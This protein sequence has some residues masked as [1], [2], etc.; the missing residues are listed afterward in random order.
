M[1]LRWP[2]WPL[3]HRVRPA[4]LVLLAAALLA[5]SGAAEPSPPGRSG[6]AT[7]LPAPPLTVSSTHG[8]LPIAVSVLGRRRLLPA[9]TTLAGCVAQLGLRPPA[10]SLLA[11]DRTVLRPAV[12]P[13]RVLLNGRPAPAATP[14][15]RDDRVTLLAGRDRVE[16]VR[17]TLLPPV[18]PDQPRNP[19]GTLVTGPGHEVLTSGSISGRLAG[20]V[21]VPSGPRHVPRAVA[22][23]FDDGP[24]PD[25][26]AKVLAILRQAHAPATFFVVGRQVLRHPELV[27]QEV[28][29]GMTVGTHS[30]SHPQGFAA[31]PPD[32]MRAEIGQGAATLAGLGMHPSLFRPPGGGWSPTVLAAAS[33]ERLRTVLWSV[34]PADWQPGTT[35]A[36]ITSRVLGAARPGAIVLLHDG[37]GDRSATVAALPQI[38]TGLRQRRL[39]LT[40]LTP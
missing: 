23:T 19:Q 9:G 6:P 3:V 17:R 4:L 21:F 31:L 8:P 24:W 7:T 11:V 12:Y 34:D 18:G 10:G 25:S 15:E 2:D 40:T 20:A 29:A 14:L 30:F 5:G 33:R 22:L 1:Q 35:A 32:R 37:G 26:T 39:A 36:Q 13:G 38:I 16:P 28:R 27:R